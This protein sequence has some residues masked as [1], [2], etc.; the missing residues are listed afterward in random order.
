MIIIN[1]TVCIDKE[2]VPAIVGDNE[3]KLLRL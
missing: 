1:G 3:S 2:I